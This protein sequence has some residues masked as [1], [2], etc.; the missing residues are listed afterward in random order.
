MTAFVPKEK[1]TAYQRWELAALDEAAGEAASPRKALR[2]P[3]TAPGKMPPMKLPTAEEIERLYTETQA[4]AYAVGYQEGIAQALIEGTRINALLDSFQQ[5]IHQLE[6][7]VA[8]QLLAVAIEVANQMFRQ[9]LRV[10]PE[11]LLPI[12]RE[13]VATLA[14]QQGHPTLSVHPQDAALV[15]THLGE[16]LSHKQWRVI[17]DDT[18]EVGGCR[19]ALGASEVDATLE[20]RWRRV[21][22]A[23][24]ISQEWLDTQP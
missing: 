6:Q 2:P 3:E 12:V 17:E 24:G 19:V 22:E 5:S 10:K 8:D 15:H 7:G 21:L 23:I 4:S 13:A 9:S 20:T 18:I 1:L 11:L 14:P 16:Q